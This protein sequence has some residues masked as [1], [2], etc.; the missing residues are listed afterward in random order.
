[1]CVGN[2]NILNNEKADLNTLRT[3][4]I[5]RTLGNIYDETFVQKQLTAFTS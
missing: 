2:L 3:A 4:G 5:F 1:M